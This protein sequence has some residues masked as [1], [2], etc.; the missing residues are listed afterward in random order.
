MKSQTRLKM[1]KQQVYYIVFYCTATIVEALIVREI[2][3]L[4]RVH[5]IDPSRVGQEI[6]SIEGLESLKT[7]HR[8]SAV[9]CGLEV[10]G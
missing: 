4:R 10:K 9:Q 2:L 6:H 5:S 7:S 3:I 1:T 8:D